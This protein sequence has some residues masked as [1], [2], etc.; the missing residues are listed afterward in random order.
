MPAQQADQNE[1][2]LKAQAAKRA[3]RRVAHLSTQQ[4]NAILLAMAD[5]LQNAEA[6]VLT[7]NANDV[8][9]AKAAGI[10]SALI[11]RLSLTPKRIADMATGLRQVAGLP[12]PLGQVVRASRLPNGLELSQIRVPLG[13]VAAIY[14][15]RPNVTVDV[16]GLC[17]KSGNATV[18]RGSSD[19]IASNIILADVLTA[20]A[21]K[22]GCP[23]GAIQLIHDTSR[24]SARALMR[25][26]GYIDCLIPRGGAGLIQAAVQNA[27]VPVIETGVGVCHVYV[28][29]AADLVKAVAIAV[30]A[31]VQRC[32]V[33]NA[34]ETLLVHAD[35]AEQFLPIVAK[36]LQAKGVELRGCRRTCALVPTAHPATEDDWY[37]EYLDLI[38][39]VKVVDSL[40]EAID[41]IE[42]YGSHHSDAI[43]TENYSNARRFCQEVDSAAVYV[44][45]STRFTDGFEFGFGAE[46]GISTQKLHARGPM[47]LNELTS[48]KYIVQGDGQ[49]RG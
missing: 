46:I 24:D 25:M 21:E 23:A 14:E 8:A 30:N 32:S 3:A 45:A 16:I 38:L 15:G 5:A 42:K 9:R 33:C 6:E 13:V 28:D 10:S 39:A 35:V 29:A 4:R 48:T 41:H 37:A 19:A 7:A 20:A 27:T 34:M 17:L 49:I 2:L 40:D 36:E 11:D 44:N 18:L 1:V 47:G 43:V 31:K 12:D 22:A 26:N